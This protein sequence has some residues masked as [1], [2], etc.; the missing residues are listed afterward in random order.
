MG[1]AFFWGCTGGRDCCEDGGGCGAAIVLEKRGDWRVAHMVVVVVGTRKSRTG[2]RSL[3]C[4]R[5]R[6]IE[7][8]ESERSVQDMLAS[9]W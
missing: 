4:T 7:G 5:L 6:D 9:F 3:R 8:G 1:F 2:Y